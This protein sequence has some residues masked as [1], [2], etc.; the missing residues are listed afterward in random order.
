MIL[1]TEKSCDDHTGTHGN[2][3]EETHKHVDHTA[4]RTDCRQC[5]VYSEEYT[6]PEDTTQE[7]ID[8]FLKELPPIIERLRAMSPLTV[9]D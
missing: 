8:Y 5:G 3:I 2:T 1:R 6:L 7:E 4:G 9:E